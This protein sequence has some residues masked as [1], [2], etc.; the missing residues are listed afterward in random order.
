M[1]NVLSCLYVSLRKVRKMIFSGYNIAV[2]N[3]DNKKQCT[4]VSPYIIFHIVLLVILDELYRCQIVPLLQ[5][6]VLANIYQKKFKR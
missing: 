3:V 1:S 2:L 4:I 5:L 6:I